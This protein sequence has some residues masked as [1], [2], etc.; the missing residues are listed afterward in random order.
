MITGS[1]LPSYSKSCN[2]REAAALLGILLP[3]FALGKGLLRG[4]S[5]WDKRQNPRLSSV[6]LVEGAD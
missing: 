6:H 1:L 4:K 5:L 3:D 2:G